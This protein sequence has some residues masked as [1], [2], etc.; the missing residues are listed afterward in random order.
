MTPRWTLPAGPCRLTGARA[1]AAL[2]D[3]PLRADAEGFVTL[4]LWLEGA[5]LRLSGPADWPA[6]PLG[7]AI[8]TPTFVDCHT[9][10][11]KGHIWPRTPNPDGTFMGAL[12]AVHADREARWTAEDVRARMG[13]ALDCAFAHGTGAIRTHLDSIGK[14]TPISWGVLRELREDWRGRVALQAAALTIADMIGTDEF[15]AV[16]D[17]VARSGGVLGCVT[18]PLPDLDARLDAFFRMAADRGLD[19]DFHVD[20]T[21][22][23]DVRTLRAIAEAKLRTRYEGRVLVGH[24]CS[25]AV[26]PDGDACATMDRVAEAG[27]SVVSLPMCNLYLQGRGGTPRWRGVTLVH[28][29]KARGVNVSFASDNTRDPFY[30]YGDLD[31][32]EVWREATR[33]CH[34]DHPVADWP[35]SFFANPAAAMGIEAGRLRDGGPADL[36][37]FPARRW[38]ELW[39]RPWA[40]RLVIRQGRASDARP[41]DYARLDALFA[42]QMEPA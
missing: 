30:A 37:I 36:V 33:I 28:E 24:C 27:L 7:G 40:D 12:A 42:Q 5:T 31:M 6:V 21:G 22:D 29:L 9:H 18:L 17:E 11:D 10:L 34:L 3:A 32:L 2:L 20:E 35:A 8:V 41:P 19:A 16:A 26:Q 15:T 14:Q 13:F 23:P 25:L 39:A 38:T 1:P 4:D